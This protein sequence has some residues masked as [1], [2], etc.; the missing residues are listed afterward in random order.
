MRVAFLAIFLVSATNA[1]ATMSHTGYGLSS[2]C[3]SVFITNYPDYD[4][5]PLSA[6]TASDKCIVVLA[7]FKSVNKIWCD[8]SDPAHPRIRERYYPASASCTPPYVDL[9]LPADGS[10][11]AIPG[12]AAPESGRF[13][14]TWVHAPPPPT[15]S[16]PPPHS[17]APHAPPMAPCNAWKTLSK[18]LPFC[19][20]PG[21]G[22][23][24]A[25]D[26]KEVLGPRCGWAHEDPREC[27]YVPL[28]YD[29]GPKLGTPCSQ[30]C[31]DAQHMGGDTAYCAQSDGSG[32]GNCFCGIY[33]GASCKHSAR[34]ATTAALP[35]PPSALATERTT[36]LVENAR[37]AVSG[38]NEKMRRSGLR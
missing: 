11:Q 9:D 16:P 8:F 29:H 38:R 33:C 21:S 23:P 10:C 15:I 32:F 24:W 7:L 20:P 3:S 35:A 19:D 34:N 14:C 6:A 27:C 12:G 17:P 1:Q 4:N 37:D 22:K 31:N 25:V 30:A 18:S 2:Q 36:K 5:V 26:L 13:Y 28:G